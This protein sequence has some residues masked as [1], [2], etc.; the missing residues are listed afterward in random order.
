MLRVRPMTNSLNIR[1]RAAKS[2]MKGD[3]CA[4]PISG[5]DQVSALLVS[6]GNSVSC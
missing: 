2:G 6:G 3:D 1:R 4:A 5:N